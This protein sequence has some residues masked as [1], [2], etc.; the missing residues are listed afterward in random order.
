MGDWSEDRHPRA[1]NGK[2]GAGAGTPKKAAARR[3]RAAKASAAKAKDGAPENLAIKATKGVSAKAT[4]RIAKAR[5]AAKAKAAE[6]VAAAKLRAKELV[7]AAKAKAAGIKPGRTKAATKTKQR[8]IV[9]KARVKAKAIVDKAKERAKA[10]SDALRPKPKTAGKSAGTTPT[11]GTPKAPARTA[12]APAVKAF[13]PK[14]EDVAALVARDTRRAMISRSAP[15]YPDHHDPQNLLTPHQLSP[16]AQTAIRD[17]HNEVAKAYGLSDRD[18]GL[19]Q[20]GTVETRT[21][22]G[23]AGA[24][25]LHWAHDGKIALASE[26]ADR[27][28]D[29]AGHD[30]AGLKVLGALSKAGNGDA[31]KTMFAY[32]VMTHEA[33]HGHGPSMTRV[34]PHVMADELTTEMA[35]RK[36]VADVHGLQVHEVRGTYGQFINPTL[37]MLAGLSGKTMPEAVAALSA[38]SIKFKK[39]SGTNLSAHDTLK[40][41]GSDAL[42]S[43]GATH[44]AMHAELHH[45]MAKTAELNSAP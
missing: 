36:I 41:V 26:V 40:Q 3:T 22:A 21:Q 28:Q 15:E 16:E 12:P 25:G 5:T 7:V 42:N 24:A 43:L 17:H 2:F 20:A 32:H 30:A 27:L 37:S 19:V 33:V 14:P 18:S 38:A 34:G 44:P 39:L 35:A 8:E 1:P 45:Y 31:I 13:G 4:A 10:K 29:H 9:A 6:V 11:V 23:I